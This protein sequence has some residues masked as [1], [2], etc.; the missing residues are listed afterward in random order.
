MDIS[1]VWMCTKYIWMCVGYMI[2]MY[3]W[4]DSPS[5]KYLLAGAD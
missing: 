1:S 4:T 2:W 5:C 3:N